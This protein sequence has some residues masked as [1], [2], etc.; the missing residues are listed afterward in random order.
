[1]IAVL[2]GILRLTV[3]RLVALNIETMLG[4]VPQI[5]YMFNLMLVYRLVEHRSFYVLTGGYSNTN[6]TLTVTAGNPGNVG[7]GT[8]SPQSQ[9]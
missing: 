6:P 7:I 2:K 9:L 8:T 3:L 5:L 4:S 1:M